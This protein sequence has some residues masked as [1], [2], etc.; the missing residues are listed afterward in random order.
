MVFSIYNELL[1]GKNLCW[2]ELAKEAKKYSID[3]LPTL[4]E[5]SSVVPFSLVQQFF[6]SNNPP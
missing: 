4:S 2:T 5:T 1:D 6:K 3:Q